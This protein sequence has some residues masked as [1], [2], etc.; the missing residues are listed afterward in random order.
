MQ[1]SI[2][3]TLST[4]GDITLLVQEATKLARHLGF[5]QRSS[6]KALKEMANKELERVPAS[7][8]D[9]ECWE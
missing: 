9:C 5:G 3:K 8:K 6:Q 4:Q 1:N 2:S 7:L